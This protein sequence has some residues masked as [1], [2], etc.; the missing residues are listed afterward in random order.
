M[1]MFVSLLGVIIPIIRL[2]ISKTPRTKERVLKLLLI[3]S[4]VFHV[5]V[6]GFFLGF[7]PHVFFADATA[8]SIGWQPGSPFQFEIGFHDGAWGI[9]GFLCLWI[10]GTFWIATGIGWS[11]FMLGA[12][13]GHIRETVIHG[14]YATY[15]FF[16]I[17]VD[18]FI[19]IY[20]LTL[21][22]LYFRTRKDLLKA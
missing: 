14:N 7:I 8:K 5:G 1:T 12:T 18:A 6:I 19:A 3:Y 17:F 4:F 2:L 11:F 13:Y 20:L 16:M 15:N 9:L 22:Y 10:R 21:L